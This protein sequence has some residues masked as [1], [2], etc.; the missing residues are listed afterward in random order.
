MFNGRDLSK[1]SVDPDP[2]HFG[3]R[4]ARIL[5]GDK[6]ECELIDAMIDPDFSRHPNRMA[7]DAVKVETLKSKLLMATKML[8]L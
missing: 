5:F 3:R 2:S 1:E 4:I 6:G 7:A 8:L